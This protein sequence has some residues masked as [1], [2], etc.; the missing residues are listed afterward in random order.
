M[1]D[2]LVQAT[3]AVRKAIGSTPIRRV[4][5][6][7]ASTLHKSRTVSADDRVPAKESAH[8]AHLGVL[9]VAWPRTCVVTPKNVRS[10][11]HSRENHVGYSVSTA[12]RRH[13]SF[14]S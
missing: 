2:L 10:Q 6:R 11:P 13:A 9:I 7:V 12:G 3:N 14:Q 5:W 8:L 4:S 1:H